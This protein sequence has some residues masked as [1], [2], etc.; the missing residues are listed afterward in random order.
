LR[1]MVCC[2]PILDESRIAKKGLPYKPQNFLF[3]SLECD[4]AV[5]EICRWILGETTGISLCTVVLFV[6]PFLNF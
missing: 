3:N 2:R 1:R 4:Q 5:R 6:V